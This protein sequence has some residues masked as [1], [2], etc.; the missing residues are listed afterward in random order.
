MAKRRVETGKRRRNKKKKLSSRARLSPPDRSTATTSD[1]DRR[2]R[3]SHTTRA[4]GNNADA[5]KR[6][7]SADRSNASEL[8]A[9]AGAGHSLV[10][11]REQVA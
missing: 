10:C 7:I 9:R 8:R 2:Q 4:R 11:I 5:R 1:D 3:V 6:K